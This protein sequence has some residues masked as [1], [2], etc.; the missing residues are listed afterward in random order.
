MVR[1]PAR[2]RQIDVRKALQATLQADVAIERIDF[3]DQGRF[4]IVPVTILSRPKD[5][6]DQV[7]D[8]GDDL[9]RELAEFEAH[10][11]QG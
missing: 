8:P 10:H 4:T 7:S 1:G 9:D 6:T 3:G 2:V 5:A 11:G